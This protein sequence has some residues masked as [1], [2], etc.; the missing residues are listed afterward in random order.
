MKKFTVFLLSIL[1]SVSFTACSITG[2][3]DY[4]STAQLHSVTA[5][6]TTTEE[7]TD[8][9]EKSTEKSTE[10][11]TEKESGTTEKPENTTGEKA[12]EP[13]GAQESATTAKPTTKKQEQSINCTVM[14]EYTKIL[15]HLDRLDN[16]HRA[17]INESGIVLSQTSVTVK[18]GESVYDA[19]KKACE[20]NG[21]YINSKSTGYGIYIVGFDGIDEKDCG[22]GSGWLYSVNGS[23]P[24]KSCDKY[25]L[26]DGDRVV[27]SYTC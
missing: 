8:A 18:E 27:F 2:V 19:L 3:D 5:A 6:K 17:L 15:D 7:K 24:G 20:A 12:D 21:V 14:I 10:E 26:N 13:A 4:D 23:F 1:L 11:S 16:S 9:T 25:I 22:S